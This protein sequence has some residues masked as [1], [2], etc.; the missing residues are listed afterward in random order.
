VIKEYRPDLIVIAQ[1]AY[2]MASDRVIAVEAGCDDYISKPIDA[3]KL[4]KMLKSYN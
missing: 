1:T 4:L 2:A 3:E